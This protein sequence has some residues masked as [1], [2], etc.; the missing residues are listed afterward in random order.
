MPVRKQGKEY[1][2]VLKGAPFFF[3]FF[4]FFSLVVFLLAKGLNFS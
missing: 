2:V 4:L 1:R 3:P